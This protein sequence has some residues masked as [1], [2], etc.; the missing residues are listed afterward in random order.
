MKLWSR[1]VCWY[2]LKQEG[3]EGFCSIQESG[4]KEA[5]TDEEK[6]LVTIMKEYRKLKS[7]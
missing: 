7:F 4:E 1:I 3:R 5:V 2:I 6:R